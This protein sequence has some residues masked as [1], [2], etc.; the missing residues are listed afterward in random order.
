MFSFCLFRGRTNHWWGD[1]KGRKYPLPTHSRTGSH[2][3]PIHTLPGPSIR[4]YLAKLEE[5]PFVGQGTPDL[6]LMAFSD[7]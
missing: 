4:H 5:L 6:V 3:L 7:A 1:Q 2:P